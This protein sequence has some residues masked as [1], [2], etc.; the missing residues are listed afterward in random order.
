MHMQR[1][2]G[3]A[4]DLASRHS[5]CLAGRDMPARPAARPS[6]RHRAGRS[7]PVLAAA[8]EEALMEEPATKEKRQVRQILER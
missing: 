4:Q 3:S 5:S 7:H 6:R 1:S 8:L 2:L